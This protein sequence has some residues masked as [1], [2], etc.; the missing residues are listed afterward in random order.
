MDNYYVDLDGG[1]FS[2]EEFA[3]YP[4]FFLFYVVI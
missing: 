4:A 3:D 1:S 2:P